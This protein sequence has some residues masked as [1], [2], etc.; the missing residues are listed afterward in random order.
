MSNIDFA[1]TLLDLA[2]VPFTPTEF[3][4]QS[5]APMLLGQTKER[6]E[7]LF[8]E[9]GYVRAVVKENWKYLALR[10]PEQAKNMTREQRQQALDDF[11]AEQRSKGRPVYTA[12]PMSPFSHVLLIPGGGDA[13]HMSMGQHPAYYEAD[14]LYDLTADPKEQ[15]NLANKP[16]HA[17]KLAEMKALL[18]AHLAKM[19]GTF[20]E[21]KE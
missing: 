5:F 4:G 9:L 10:Y 11:N 14:Q 20:A 17:S 19:P 6:T 21:L 7:P 12:D 3:D 15:V 16:E 18:K 8:F 1:P 2:G 13:E